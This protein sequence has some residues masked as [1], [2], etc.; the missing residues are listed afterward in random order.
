M[1][2]PEWVPT[3]DNLAFTAAVRRLD[4][5]VLGLIAERRRWVC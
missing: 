4:R 5:A 1:V 2:L 3:P